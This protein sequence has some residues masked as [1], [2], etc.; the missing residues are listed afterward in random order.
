MFLGLTTSS[1]APWT[2]LHV[3]GEIDMA[4]A[5]Q[6]RQEVVRVIDRGDHDLVLDL[7]EVAFCDSTGIGVVVAAVKRARTAGGDVRVVC[8]NERLREMF[9]ITRLDRVFDLFDLVD[10]AVAGAVPGA[11]TREAG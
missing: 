11:E 3:R 6:L 8:V 2:V 4:S 1:R 10:E 9:A 5:P 7:T